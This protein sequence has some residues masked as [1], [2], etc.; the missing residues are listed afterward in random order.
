MNENGENNPLLLS[1][2]CA[3]LYPHLVRVLRPENRYN[4]CSAGAVPAAPRA[5]QLRFLTKDDGTVSVHPSS[6]LFACGNYESPYVV[7]HEKMKTSRIFI[8]ECSMVP[9]FPL[10]LCGGSEIH[11]GLDRGTFVLSIDDG[12][13][14]FVCE[15]HQVLIQFS[16]QPPPFS[17]LWHW[18]Y[19]Q[20]Y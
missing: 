2:L 10:I 8:R 18:I 1:V 19:T 17:P 3:S 20:Y 13:I 9:A 15:S 5:Q 14:K 4:Q 7:Y 12:W 16:D 6:V 11:V